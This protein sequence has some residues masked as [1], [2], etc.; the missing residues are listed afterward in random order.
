M[1]VAWLGTRGS[2]RT[3]LC[4]LQK[5]DSVR[6]ICGPCSRAKRFED[7][8]YGVAGTSKV[9]RLEES[10][11][12]VENRIMDLERP[13]ARNSP[14]P[15]V[16]QNPYTSAFT[17]NHPQM[18][19]G[20]QTLRLALDQFSSHAPEA[21]FFLNQNRF[22]TACLRMG[23]GYDEPPAALLS[24]VCLWAACVSTSEP[25]AS[26]ENSFLS[27]TLQLATTVLSSGHRLKILYGIQTEVLLSQYFLHKGRLVEAQYHLSLAVSHVVVGGL[28]SIRSSRVQSPI[29][30]VQDP[31]E[32]GEHIIGFWTVFSMDKIWSPALN[33]ASNFASGGPGA[34]DVDTPWPLEMDAYERNQHSQLQCIN[35]IQR[36]IEDVPGD[37]HVGVSCLAILAKSA[38]LYERATVVAGQ[39][40][41]NMSPPETDA[42]F[43]SFSE[44]N[45]RIKKFRDRLP[46]PN[47]IAS[48]TA[49]TKPRIIMTHS[50]AH[51]ATIQLNHPFVAVNPQCRELCLAA[52]R[53]IIGII[54]AGSLRNVGYIN[55]I[56]GS[57]WSATGQVIVEEIRR[58]RAVPTAAAVVADLMSAHDEIAT[59]VAFYSRKC[60]F[61]EFQL[62]QF[63]SS[64]GR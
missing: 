20:A 2:G 11:H 8:E 42:F 57:I 43:K 7:C 60:P 31:I 17:T 3:R 35:T 58:L 9:R 59:S 34:P 15:V 22:R 40:H 24:A 39:W 26:Q 36:F 64:T 33:F 47:S 44:L 29:S 48:S 37:D 32:E 14:P 6:P 49:A 27:Q 38:I 54:R 55:P 28:S 52:C 10:I 56:L 1:T 18:P 19:I 45:Q 21:G 63:M 53:S 4:G 41:A 30:F 62:G 50:V 51:A 25:L 46:S 61:M 16:L 13:G 5:C 23:S 12:Q